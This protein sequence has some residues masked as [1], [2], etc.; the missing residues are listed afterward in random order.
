MSSAKPA[1][2]L[3]KKESKTTKGNNQLLMSADHPK[4]NDTPKKTGCC[5]GTSECASTD[6]TKTLL[7]PAQ[8]LVESEHS[9]GSHKGPKTRIVIK[10][11]VGFKNSITIRGKGAGLS[12][13]RGLSLKNTKADE[14]MWETETPFTT[15]E[16]KVLINDTRYELGENHTLRCGASIHYAPKF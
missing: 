15:G 7:K 12:W 5:M 1:P 10:F 11:D 6:N 13:D 2:T 4:S 16:F 8:S 3:I 14:W 9:L